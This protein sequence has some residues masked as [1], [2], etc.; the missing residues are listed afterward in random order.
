MWAKAGTYYDPLILQVFVNRLGRYPPGSILE[1]TD[2]RWGVV[3]GSNRGGR[4]FD[5]PIVRIAREADG[6]EPEGFEMTDL[7]YESGVADIVRPQVLMEENQEEDDS[8]DPDAYDDQEDSETGQAAEVDDPFSKPTIYRT[9]K[10]PRRTS[11]GSQ[12]PTPPADAE[13]DPATE[14]DND[15]SSFD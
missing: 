13:E 11:K 6:S 2:G 8:W 3:L 12:T 10:A 1:L 9:P 5:K 4:M 7:S 14:D 15:D